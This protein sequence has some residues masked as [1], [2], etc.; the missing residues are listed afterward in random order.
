MEKCAIYWC[1]FIAASSRVYTDKENIPMFKW[2]D[3]WL[4]A[5]ETLYKLWSC[6]VDDWETNKNLF[7]M[8][9]CVCFFEKFDWNIVAWDAWNNGTLATTRVGSHKLRDQAQREPKISSSLQR[10]NTKLELIFLTRL[11]LDPFWEYGS[12]TLPMVY[13]RLVTTTN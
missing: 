12:S 6:G 8:A 4:I 5:W 11:D 9:E 10:F 7:Q 13:H 2:R 1:Q 3:T